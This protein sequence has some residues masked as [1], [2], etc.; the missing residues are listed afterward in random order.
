MTG[1]MLHLFESNQNKLENG[2]GNNLAGLLH[3]VS[4][5]HLHREWAVIDWLPLFPL[6]SSALNSGYWTKKLK[7]RAQNFRTK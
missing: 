1:Q 3:K 5:H 6:N 4:E 2:C 7:L